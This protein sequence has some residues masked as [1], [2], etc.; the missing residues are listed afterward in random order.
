MTSTR[1]YALREIAARM[2]DACGEDKTVWER[3]FPVADSLYAV[4]DEIDQVDV[5]RRLLTKAECA[6]A[7]REDD[8]E[9]FGRWARRLYDRNPS[10]R[11]TLRKLD[12]AVRYLLSFEALGFT[13]AVVTPPDG[14]G[15]APP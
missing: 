2:L 6:L 4:A 11:I 12:S 8:I 14:T 1:A 13:E 5:D 3:M 9:A 15:R 10:G 7:S